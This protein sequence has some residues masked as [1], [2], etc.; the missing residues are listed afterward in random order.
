MQFVLS[1]LL[2]LHIF[3]SL[4]LFLHI[5]LNI[6]SL[7]S[8]FLSLLLLLPRMFVS[9][10]LHPRI[11]LSLLLFLL[12]F[13]NLLL[14]LHIFF[15]L[16]LL[17]HPI[18]KNKNGQSSA[19][20]SLCLFY[21]TPLLLYVYINPCACHNLGF[22]EF[23]VWTLPPPGI[24]SSLLSVFRIICPPARTYLAFHKMLRVLA[25]RHCQ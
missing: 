1:L 8:I 7:L 21:L 16:L 11:F 17:L 22:S 5:F 13:P 6:L 23:A 20:Y 4:L 3:L 12:I 15:N 25:V 19:V 10:L 18:L 14:L 2:P 9:L 24:F